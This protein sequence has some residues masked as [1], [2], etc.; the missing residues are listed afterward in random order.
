M[1]L[2]R[3]GRAGSLMNE[4]PR[5]GIVVNLKYLSAWTL[6][7]VFDTDPATGPAL[8]PAPGAV[9]WGSPKNFCFLHSGRWRCCASPSACP[10]AALISLLWDS[11]IP[12]LKGRSKE[13]QATQMRWV[14]HRSASRPSLTDSTSSFS[15]S[16]PVPLSAGQGPGKAGTW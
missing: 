4:L 1:V 9:F 16:S 3:G 2:G 11:C 8:P 5:I 15:A 10:S 7:V 13:P 12:L 14:V 6:L